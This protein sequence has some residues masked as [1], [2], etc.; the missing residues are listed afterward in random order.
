VETLDLTFESLTS[1]ATGASSHIELDAA[2]GLEVG[3]LSSVP[4]NAR[5]TAHVE[6]EGATGEFG[7]CLRE[8]G[9]FDRG[10]DL[11]FLPSEHRVV[12]HDQSIWA[13][14]GLDAAITLDIILKDDIIDV[15]IDD[16]RC[17]INRCP[18]LHG[19]RLAFYCRNGSVT[20]SAIEARPLA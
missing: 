20:F 10:Y 12:L 5:I 19:N 2:H 11:C 15:C 4:R 6:A 7:I 18:E 1:G 8:E 13:V 16:R 14:D 3:I 17:L 9:R